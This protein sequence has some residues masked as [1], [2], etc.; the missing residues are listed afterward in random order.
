[1]AKRDIRLTPTSYIVLGLIAA[2]GR[3]TPYDLKRVHQQGIGG[4]WSLNHAQLY[5]EPDRLAGG[6][7]LSVEREEGGRRR[8][9]Y[10]LTDRGRDA[11]SAWLS[12]PTSEFTELRDPGLLQLFFGA[13]PG[14][15]AGVQRRI[16]AERLAEY[17]ELQRSASG[18][19]DG[20]RLVLESGI[21]HEREWLRFWEG[22]AEG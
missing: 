14:A 12:T 11:F 13:S 7:Y 3:A 1:M 21:G 15:L 2:T 4:F 5:A 18:W 16:H 10:E 8:K 20:A 6:G 17:E 22:V 9:L 19:P